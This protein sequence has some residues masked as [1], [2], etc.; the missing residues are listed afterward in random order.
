MTNI[1][2]KEE[3]SFWVL[4]R[5]YNWKFPNLGWNHPEQVLLSVSAQYH[6]RH[7]AEHYRTCNSC[8]DDHQDFMQEQEMDA[9]MD[10]AEY[11]NES[12]DF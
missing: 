2:V 8:W 4:E 9:R 3:R 11:Q 6:S 10:A 1:P 7:D 12:E 5:V